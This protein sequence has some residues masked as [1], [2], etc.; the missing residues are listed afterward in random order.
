MRW[1]DEYRY[2]SA[3]CSR[4]GPV[5]HGPT[6][7]ERRPRHRRDVDVRRCVDDGEVAGRSEYLSAGEHEDVR[8]RLT[9]TYSEE[10]E[11][12]A[13]PHLDTDG[14]GRFGYTGGSVDD[15]YPTERT[16]I[17]DVAQV[18]RSDSE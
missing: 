7:G 15:T 14:D 13:V 4:Y 1:D 6:G 12:Y 5:G 3:E 17:Y 9:S 18:Q 11:L 16:R 8:I 10:M 2:T